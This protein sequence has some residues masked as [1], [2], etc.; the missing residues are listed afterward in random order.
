M[1]ILLVFTALAT[2]LAALGLVVAAQADGARTPAV[3]RTPLERSVFHD[4]SS[5]GAIAR[6]P[7]TVSRVRCVDAQ[8]FCNVTRQTETRE[9]F[10][11]TRSRVPIRSVEGALRWRYRGID[12]AAR[13]QL[14]NARRGRTL[15]AISA[16]SSVAP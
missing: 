11:V 10:R 14:D 2:G 3:A 12:E 4:Q 5:A 8:G 9:F 1:R 6:P 15:W 16:T 7:F 13:A